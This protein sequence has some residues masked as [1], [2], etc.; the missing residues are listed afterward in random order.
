MHRLPK[1]VL[2]LELEYDF[3]RHPT[4]LARIEIHEYKSFSEV[5]ISEKRAENMLL[6]PVLLSA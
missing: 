1:I 2:M 4:A 3:T 5:H 6:L